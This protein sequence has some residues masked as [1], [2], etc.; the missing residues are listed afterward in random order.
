MSKHNYSQYANKSRDNKQNYSKPKVE[1]STPEVKM[2]FEHR[3]QPL[4]RVVV[5]P[6]IDPV[7]TPIVETVET[8][9]L[10]KSATGIVNNC[11]KLNV[12]SKPSITGEVLCVLNTYSEV[13]IDT[14]KSVSD[15]LY[16]CTATGVEGYCMRKFIKANL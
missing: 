9:T 16:V 8:V 14:N 2:E 11:T 7:I 1:E 15:W 3:D 12:R 10:P 5:E 4:D 13:E 6:I